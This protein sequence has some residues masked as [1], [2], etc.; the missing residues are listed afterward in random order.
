MT[1]KNC[2]MVNVNVKILHELQKR[3]KKYGI[4]I[5]FQVEDA[6]IDYLKKV[7]GRS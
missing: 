6:L 5:N 3:K 2:R 7:K 4:S 1:Q